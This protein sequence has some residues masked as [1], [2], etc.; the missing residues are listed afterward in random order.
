[1]KLHIKVLVWTLRDHFGRVNTGLVGTNMAD[2]VVYGRGE[3]E[4]HILITLT[5]KKRNRKRNSILFLY[6]LFWALNG[7]IS[8]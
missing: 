4:F 2:R 3:N 5:L 6:G 7:K 1:M 8:I